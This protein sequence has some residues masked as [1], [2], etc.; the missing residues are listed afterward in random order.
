MSLVK[1]VRFR[2]APTFV[3]SIALSGVRPEVA[4]GRKSQPEH[5]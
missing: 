5:I 2:I 3:S 4:Q 1:A